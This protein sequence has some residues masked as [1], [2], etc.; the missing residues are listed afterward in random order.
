MKSNRFKSIKNDQKRSKRSKRSITQTSK[1]LNTSKDQSDIIANKQA[2]LRTEIVK[3]ET[4]KHTKP[5]KRRRIHGV[6][7]GKPGFR[8]FANFPE[9]KELF[10]K[11]GER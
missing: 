6:K 2:K 4:P 9:K 10:E 3:R 5:S 8:K 7:T 11:A 1:R